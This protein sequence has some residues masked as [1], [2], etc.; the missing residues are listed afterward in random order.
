MEKISTYGFLSGLPIRENDDIILLLCLDS[1]KCANNDTFINFPINTLIPIAP[2]IF[3]RYNGRLGVNEN[4]VLK[5]HNVEHIEKTIGKTIQEAIDIINT[6]GEMTFA[7]I[8]KI[9]SEKPSD[10]A[11]LLSNHKELLDKTIPLN[12]PNRMNVGLTFTMEHRSIYN[13]MCCLGIYPNNNE[14]TMRNGVHEHYLKLS[15]FIKKNRALCKDYNLLQSKECLI[16]IFKEIYNGD[17]NKFNEDTGKDNPNDFAFETESRFCNKFPMPSYDSGLFALYEGL[18]GRPKWDRVGFNFVDFFNFI[19]SLWMTKKT[20]CKSI[21]G[22]N[23]NDTSVMAMRFLYEE[24]K[25]LGD[26]IAGRLDTRQG[27]V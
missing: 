5:D 11:N 26:L 21:V 4:T 12:M 25:H 14:D 23:D 9:V 19:R 2:P 20:I 22:T 16:R 10:Y 15:D 27:R 18:K 7:A 3:C 13:R 6:D 17:S 8:D 1:T 24:I